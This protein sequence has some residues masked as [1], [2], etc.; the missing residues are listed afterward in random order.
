MKAG[1]AIGNGTSRIH[2]DLEALRGHGP[3]IGCN[4]LYRDFEP[5]I[6]VAIDRPPRKEL[7]TVTERN[8]KLLTGM[9]NR[10]WLSLDGIPVMRTKDVNRTI[11][12]NS[13]LIACSYLAKMMECTRVYMLGFDFFRVH[14]GMTTND[15]YCEQIFIKPTF[16]RPFVI[17]SKD[18]K[19][20]EFVRVGP[21]EPSDHDYWD[22]LSTWF[23]LIDYPELERRIERNEL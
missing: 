18:C 21:I 19:E 4:W 12:L 13:G 5:D 6:L 2:F 23:T 20:T 11:G 17:L 10:K 3:I 9:A 14:K 22:E 15:V 16:H 1:F 8:F 7:A